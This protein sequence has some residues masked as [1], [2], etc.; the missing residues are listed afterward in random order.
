LRGQRKWPGGDG[1][2]VYDPSPTSPLRYSRNAHPLNDPPAL[3]AKGRIVAYCGTFQATDG[4]SWIQRKSRFHSSSRLIQLPE[5]RERSGE[6]RNALRDNLGWY[7]N[8]DVTIQRLRHRLRAATWRVQPNSSTDVHLHREETSVA[9]R[10]HVSLFLRR[11]RDKL[12]RHRWKH[13]LPLSSDSKPTRARIQRCL[14]PRAWCKIG[15]HPEAC[16]QGRAAGPRIE[17]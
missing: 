16:E 2:S 6:F 5:M 10:V 13:G 8:F 17:P 11:D 12:W 14:A 7:S 15:G 9:L 1:R 4:E 3:L